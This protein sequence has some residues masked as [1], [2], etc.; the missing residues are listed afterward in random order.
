[1]FSFAPSLQE[2]DTLLY[3]TLHLPEAPSSFA[4]T[5]MV[6]LQ[7]NKLRTINLKG[8]FEDENTAAAIGKTDTGFRTGNLENGVRS[9]Q[10][11]G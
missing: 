2:Q 11:T 1:M 9:F 5:F 4:H 8:R 7:G 3:I 10:K 6:Y